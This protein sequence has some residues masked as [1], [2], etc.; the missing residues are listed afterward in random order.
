MWVAAAINYAYL[1]WQQSHP[2]TSDTSNMSRLD[3][4]LQQHEKTLRNELAS[5]QK[6]KT[7]LEGEL[8]RQSELI[9]QTELDLTEVTHELERRGIDQQRSNGTTIREEPDLMPDWPQ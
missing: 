1:Q 4:A 2:V 3:A 5:A 9:T 8:K 7:E 6:K